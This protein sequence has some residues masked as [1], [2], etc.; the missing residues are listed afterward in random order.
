MLCA[1][2]LANV[3]ELS[4]FG[5]IPAS[6]LRDR[7]KKLMKMG[8]AD[9]VSHSLN[10]LGPHAHLRYFP[11][12]KG[13]DAGAMVEWGPNTFLREYPV[14]RQ[15]F[16]LLAE[17]L[18]AVAITLPRRRPGRRRRLAGKA[19]ESGPLPP[20]SLRHADHPVRGPLGGPAAPGADAA[21]GQP[22]LPAE[23]P[24]EPAAQ[25]AR[26]MATLV[27][28]H[29]DQANRRAVRTLGDAMHHRATFVATEGELL[30]GDHRGVV[31]Q[32]CG[33]DTELDPPGGGG[34]RRV[35]ERHHVA[36]TDRLAGG[37]RRGPVGNATQ[38]A[39]RRAE[40]RPGDPLSPTTCAP[41]CR[42]RRSC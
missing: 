3:D 4:R 11:T 30:A 35:P 25:P 13:I 37:F 39:E 10:V 33:N 28:A 40:A 26:P 16:R 6:T 21:L 23:N 41:P 7:L 5:S 20:G 15:W 32:Q 1:T 34:P 42:S 36:W 38:G 17:R 12:E 31:W 27:L 24:G 29:S 19:G 22:A 14:S 2:P 18:D 8:M 9:S